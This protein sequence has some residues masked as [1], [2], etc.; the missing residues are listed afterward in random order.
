[1]NQTL[2]QEVV[3]AVLAG[4][5]DAYAILVNRYQK[6]IYNLAYRMTDSW[7]DAA[8]LTQEAFVKAFEQLHR[9]QTERKFFPWLYTIALNH[10]KNFLKADRS[11]RQMD[12][13]DCE[14]STPESRWT[15]SEKALCDRLDSN[16]CYQT[17]L[18][19]PEEYREALILRFKEELS[20]EE[21]AAALKISLSG[22]KMRIHRGLAKLRQLMGNGRSDNEAANE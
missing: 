10:A 14:L 11:W 16:R 15:P 21:I 18:T 2:D 5:V 7:S 20:M 3:S 22:A 19:L 6:P 1:M 13:D 8:D 9:F 4:D 12:L 17:L